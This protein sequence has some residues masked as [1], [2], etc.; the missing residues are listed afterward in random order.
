LSIGAL[1]F[2][3]GHAALP[4]GGRV[5]V[6]FDFNQTPIL[7]EDTPGVLVPSLGLPALQGA[8]MTVAQ[9]NMRNVVYMPDDNFGTPPGKLGTAAVT[10]LVA[11]SID[12]YPFMAPEALGPQFDA[13]FDVEVIFMPKDSTVWP[14]PV[15]NRVYAE[16]TRVNSPMNALPPPVLPS[17]ITLSNLPDGNLRS[18]VISGVDRDGDYYGFRDPLWRIYT[19]ASTTIIPFTDD[20][21]PFSSGEEVWVSLEK[22][23]FDV[24]F[25]Y[26]LFPVDLILRQQ[27][28]YSEDS[29]ALIVP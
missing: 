29:Y 21:N 7:N 24:P 5:I 17:A 9:L 27:A 10:D 13:G 18:V 25:D 11:G 16:A 23:G 1:D 3:E 26:D 14:Y 2:P 22:S 6:G 12:L 28:V 8:S 4:E 20:A 19:P 15:M